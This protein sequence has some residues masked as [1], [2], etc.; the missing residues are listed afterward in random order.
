MEGLKF[1]RESLATIKI[2]GYWY[3][4]KRDGKAIMVMEEKGRPDKFEEG[5]ARLKYNG[6]I[7]FFN[8]DLDIVIEPLYDFAFPFHDGISEV[9]VGCRDL[10]F[11]GVDL[12]D[13]GEWKR[14]DRKGVII[15]E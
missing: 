13:G 2:D 3:Y 4:V 6:K 7:G 1:S 8:R 9:C 14:I 12:L 10:K 11:D 5:L 15:E